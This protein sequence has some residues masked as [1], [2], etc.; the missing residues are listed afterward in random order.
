MNRYVWDLRYTAPDALQHTYPIAALYEHTHAEPQGPLAV[1][2][3]Y[4][5]R[6]TVDGKTYKQPLTVAMDPRVKITQA[7]LMRQL[8]FE[9][10]I[11]KLITQ[12]FDMHDQA[13]KFLTEAGDRQKAL[14]DNEQAKAALDGLS[15]FQGKAQKLQGEIQRGFGGFGKPKPSFTLLNGELSNLSETAGQAD[16]APTDA[17]RVAYRDYCHDL[18]KVA[19]QWSALMKTDLPAVNTQLTQQKQP[20]LTP[21]MENA[22]VPACE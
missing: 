16:Q 12:T 20:P 18:T 21:V 15:Q 22:S 8:D 7:E 14:K 6:L 11:D 13:A 1:P 17:M 5:V 2:G 9:R 10:Q 19:Q 4:E 3:L